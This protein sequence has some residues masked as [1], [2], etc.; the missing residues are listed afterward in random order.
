[1]VKMYGAEEALKTIV[2][3]KD[4]DTDSPTNSASSD[5]E[6]DSCEDQSS[7]LIL[8]PRVIVRPIPRRGRG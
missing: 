8:F 2:E 6:T 4:T 1:M 3:T 7:H 5:M